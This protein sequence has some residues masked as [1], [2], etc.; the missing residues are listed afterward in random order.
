MKNLTNYLIIITLMKI[1]HILM[2]KHN[3]VGVENYKTR[4]IESHTDGY[5]NKSF[6]KS[7]IL[8]FLENM[9]NAHS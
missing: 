3:F 7:N 8:N 4:G 1:Y 2:K 6:I 5:K 9:L